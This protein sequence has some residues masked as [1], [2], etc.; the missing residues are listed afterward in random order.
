MQNIYLFAGRPSFVSLITVSLYCVRSVG[1]IPQYVDIIPN[2]FTIVKNLIYRANFFTFTQIYWRY[3]NIPTGIFRYAADGHDGL[4]PCRSK[5]V[6]HLWLLSN[7]PAFPLCS[8]RISYSFHVMPKQE[9]TVNI[10]TERHGI[11]PVQACI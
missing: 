11:Y 6:M 10:L 4:L 7:H 8:I 5:S 9:S 3:G 1:I 2:I